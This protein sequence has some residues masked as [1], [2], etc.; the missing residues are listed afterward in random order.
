MKVGESFNIK[1]RK[2]IFEKIKNVVDNFVKYANK[3]EVSQ[4]LI[5]EVEENRPKL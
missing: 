5:N 3:N 2:A 4:E 1:K